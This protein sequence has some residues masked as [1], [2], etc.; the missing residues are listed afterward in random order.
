VL[1]AGMLLTVALGILAL[2]ALQRERR[3]SRLIDRQTAERDRVETELRAAELRHRLLADNAT[4]TILA[5]G[6][7]GRITYVSPASSEL[8]GHAP[9]EIVGRQPHDFVHPDDHHAVTHA[10]SRIADEGGT[11]TVTSRLRHREGHYVWIEAR[12]R[13]VHDADTGAPIEGQAIVRDVSERV[14]AEAAL[15]E[16]V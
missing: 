16:S 2:H 7:D 1:V 11:I 10:R 5:F 6:A 14:A 3:A 12:V 4:D 9:D 15:R 8:I 13:R